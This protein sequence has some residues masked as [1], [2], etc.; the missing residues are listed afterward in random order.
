MKKARI[1]EKLLKKSRQR[2]Y[3]V[4]SSQMPKRFSKVQSCKLY[5]SKYVI[6]SKQTTNTEI[7][8]FIAVLVFQVIEP[9]IINR[10]DNR[11]CE[12]SRL[13]FKKIANCCKIITS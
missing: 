6:A 11:N 3:K 13:F 4:R 12:K 8:A 1:Q 7:F 5:N 2:K 9:I 10:R